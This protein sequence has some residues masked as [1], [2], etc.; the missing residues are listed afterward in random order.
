[1]TT[2]FNRAWHL[3]RAAGLCL[4]ATLSIVGCSPLLTLAAAALSGG[5]SGS[6]PLTSGIFNGT[7]SLAQSTRTT[8]MVQ[9]QKPTEQAIHDVLSHTDNQTISD[10]CLESLPP[11][12]TLPVTKCITRLSCIP[13]LSR[14][15][16]MRTCPANDFIA[17]S[18]GQADIKGRSPFAGPPWRWKGTSGL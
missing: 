5:S 2:K 1:M 11:D 17:Q 14:P 7:P 10:S 4:F 3:V 18:G 6:A 15:L 16:M 12:A 8:S 9:N 13:G